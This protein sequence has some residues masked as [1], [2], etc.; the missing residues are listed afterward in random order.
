[1]Q[2]TNKA[3]ATGQRKSRKPLVAAAVASGALLPALAVAGPAMASALVPAHSTAG[4]TTAVEFD[5]FSRHKQGPQGNRGWD[6]GRSGSHQNGGGPADQR[7]G[8]TWH[9]KQDG[10]GQTGGGQP[11][12]GGQPTT[13][14]GTT[15]TG[16]TGTGSGTGGQAHAGGIGPGFF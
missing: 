5:S 6:G 10:N 14:T 11:A 16:T 1:M 12:T 7:S 3:H 4:R 15:G 9:P 13:G 8:W 2:F